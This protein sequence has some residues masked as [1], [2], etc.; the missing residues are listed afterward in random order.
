MEAMATLVSYDE[1]ESDREFMESVFDYEICFSTKTGL[2][3]I[4]LTPCRHVYCLASMR[5][6]TEVAINDGS[7]IDLKCPSFHCKESIQPHQVKDAVSSELFTKY[8]ELLLKHS[9]NEMSDIF[10]CPRPRLW[11]S[12]IKG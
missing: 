10:Y 7:V 6:H 5:K 2:E 12:I 1:V 9:L 4:Q 3:C 11:Q 8:D